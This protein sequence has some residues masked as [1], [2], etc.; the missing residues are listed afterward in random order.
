VPLRLD[1]HGSVSVVFHRAAAAPSR[2]QPKPTRRTLVAVAGPWTVTF[3]AGWSAPPTVR[4]DSLASWTAH[5]DSGVKYF[6]GTA[7]YAAELD[8]PRESFAR[9]G[10]LVLDLGQVREIAEVTVNGKQIG[11]VLWKPPYAADVT[12]A[13]RPGRNHVAPHAG[14]PGPQ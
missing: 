6:S 13:L 5:P 2:E 3:P 14:A 10:R 1:P 12:G 11:G 7:T 4:L 9:G 8:V